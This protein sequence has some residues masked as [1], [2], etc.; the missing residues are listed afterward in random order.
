MS[1]PFP[2]PSVSVKEVLQVSL[3]SRLRAVVAGDDYL[4]GDLDDLVYDDDQAE[5]MPQ[6]GRSDGGALATLGDSNPFDLSD[7]LG[8]S[9][10]IGMPGISS[11][12]AGE[13]DGAAQLRW[14][15]QAIQ[16]LRERKTV[17]LNLTMMEPTRLS[18]PLISSQA[19]PSPSMGTRNASARAFSSP[20][21]A[22]RSPT[23]RRRRSSPTVS[24]AAD[25]A[26]RKRRLH[27]RPGDLKPSETLA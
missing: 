18:G 21:A 12:A 8:G 4:D 24:H 10:V 16:A 3:I 1:E 22:S 23:P 9:K 27:L 17:I 14:I 19:A 11:A 20:P 6:V 26:D 25:V 2:N 13:S 5:A 15:P 7:E